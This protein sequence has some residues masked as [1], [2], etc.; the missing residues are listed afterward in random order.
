MF[1]HYDPTKL[2]VYTNIGRLYNIANEHYPGVNTVLSSTEPQE[3][4][5]YWAKWRSQPKNAAKSE[6]AKARGSLLH[7]AVE[8]Q[9]K[10]KRYTEA[11]VGVKEDLLD[12]VLPYW[13]SIQLACILPK[14]SCIALI[15]SAV[16]HPIGKYA[17]TVDLVAEVE[18]ELCVVDWKTS[19]RHKESHWCT[20][21]GLQCA[22]YAGAVNRMYQT[23]IATGVVVIA[24]PGEE[25]Q[26]LRYNLKELWIPWL[27][28]VCQYWQQQDTTQVASV[29]YQLG[30]EYPMLA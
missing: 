6:R 23:E 16:W 21:Y 22:A 14:L 7:K 4:K 10:G 20:N 25:A 13:Q 12:E 15:E 17:G 5:D 30:Q 9:L 24:V 28:L 18:G 1:R 19:A 27:R 26:V 3:Q 11:F 8:Y 2:H 29:L